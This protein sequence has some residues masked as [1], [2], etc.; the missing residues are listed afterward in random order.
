MWSICHPSSACSTEAESKEKRGVWDPV[1]SPYVGLQSRL[2]H[3]YQGQPYARVDL[4]PMPESTLSP[5]Q[6]LASVLAAIHF[7]YTLTPLIGV[8]Q[9]TQKVTVQLCFHSKCNAL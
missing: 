6:N 2:L 5:S 1:T 7:L 9:V 4:N 3:I 8:D